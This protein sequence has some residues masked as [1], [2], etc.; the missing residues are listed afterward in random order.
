MPFDYR[1][2]RWQTSWGCSNK[3]A[4]DGELLVKRT[5]LESIIK[6]RNTLYSLMV[7][8]TVTLVKYSP[9]DVR[10]M[11][12]KRFNKNADKYMLHNFKVF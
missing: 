3:T 12:E 4:E 9:G 8:F 5:R 2:A 1:L 7:G 6:I 11:I 10:I